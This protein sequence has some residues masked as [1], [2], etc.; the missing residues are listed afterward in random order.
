MGD[1]MNISFMDEPQSLAEYGI[2]NTGEFL[3]EYQNSKLSIGLYQDSII[4]AFEMTRS[5]VNNIHK[6]WAMRLCNRTSTKNILDFDKP[7][8]TSREVISMFLPKITYTGKPGFYVKEYE[9]YVKY[10]DSEIKVDIRNGKLVSGT[11]DKK[12]LGSKTDGSLFDVINIEKGPEETLETIYNLQQVINNFMFHNGATFGFKDIFI[13]KDSRE[14]I[15]LQVDKIIEGSKLVHRDLEE[16]KIIPPVEMSLEE[17]YEEKQMAALEHGDEFV[18]PIMEKIDPDDNWFYRFVYSGSKGDRVNL[19][20]IFS[21]I[22]SI[23]IGGKRIKPILNGRTTINFLRDE[24][25]PMARGYNPD[26]FTMGIAPITLPFSAMEARHE[27]IEVAL[28]TAKAGTLNRN[29]SKNLENIIVGNNLSTVKKNRVVQLLYGENGIDPRKVE[30]VKFPTIMLN[31]KDL[32]SGYHASTKNFNKI[33]HNKNV[34]KILDEEFMQIRK[35]RDYFRELMIKNEKNT[36]K[37]F[38]LTDTLR[39][40]I[41]PV[42][43][44]QNVKEQC[45]EYDVKEEIIDPVKTYNKVKKFID[46]LGYVYSNSMQKNAKADIPIYIETAVTYFKILLRSTICMKNILEYNMS[47]RVLDMV[48]E[49]I[50][51]KLT[52]SFV[53]YGLCVGIIAS[54]SISEPITQF[55]LDAKHRSGLK[56]QKINPIERADEIFKNSPTDKMA[57][58]IMTLVPKDEYKFNKEEVSRIADYIEMLPFKRFVNSYAIFIENFANPVHPDYKAEIKDF[59]QFLLHSMVKPPTDLI[60]WCI[61]FQIKRE[62]LILKNIKLKDIYITLSRKFPDIYIVHS[63]QNSDNIYIRVYVRNI[64]FKTGSIDEDAIKELADSLNDT[65]IRGVDKII[66]TNVIEVPHT[67]IKED[68]S[69]EVKKLYAIETNGTNLGKILENPY[70]NPYECHTNSLEEIEQIYGIEAA[71]NKIVS[72]L[73][74][75]LNETYNYEHASIYADEMTYNGRITNIQRS[76]LGKREVDNVLL[77]ASFGDPM[78]ALSQAAIN[79]QTDYLYGLSAQLVVGTAP[80]FGTTYNDIA[81]V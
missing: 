74:T 53:D 2:S 23:G 28:S 12:I 73:L 11:M 40:P 3:K 67:V 50:Y 25:N 5:K 57:V 41:N 48:L 16:G 51:L 68:G 7:K 10:D 42:R 46:D 33:Y 9:P 62:E 56:K 39:M 20:A 78:K 52:G 35:D 6:Y 61:R 4:G 22:G 34:Q 8:Y 31:D 65:I 24:S 70:L 37:V 64:S 81:L 55:L 58:K 71:R 27:L 21:A 75:I 32:E 79:S 43:I 66:S 38:L 15:K 76:G 47:D 17:F 72:E 63:P 18:T 29:A 13:H 45:K 30:K 77:R 36:R 59:K 26:N 60:N 44:I 1:E 54:Q 14:K 49:R 19:T 69:M 80:R